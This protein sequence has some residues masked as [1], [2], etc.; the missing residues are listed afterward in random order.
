MPPRVA[1]ARSAAA[2]AAA[3]LV[4]G[5]GGC[6]E[7]DRPEPDPGGGTGGG[8]AGASVPFELV[9]TDDVAVSPD[10]RRVLADCWEG[11]CTWDVA[12]GALTLVPDRNQVAVAPDWSTVATVDGGDVVLEG[13]PDGAP[14][15]TFRGLDDAE[16]TDGSPVTAVAFS[17]DGQLLAAAGLD[18]RVVVWSVD[19]GAEQAAFTAA[20]APQT[21]VFSPDGSRLA[22][23]GG[24]PVEVRDTA[25][26]Q[27]VATVQGSGEAGALAWS[28]DGRALL[29]PGAGDVP[30][31]WEAPAFEPVEELPGVRLHEL[32]VSP[33]GRTV[34]VTAFDTT[35]VRLWRPRA[36]AGAGGVRSLVGHVA[37]PGAVAFA[38]DGTRLYSVAADDGVRAWDV[39]SGRPVARTFEVPEGPDR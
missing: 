25:D 32:A 14:V 30:T 35:A 5:L 4:T 9:L 34:A 39:A 11:I 29:G 20:Y 24:G 18:G 15:R 38:P 17:P 16:V 12:T 23:A 10:G 8:T 2:L 6:G 27:A 33:D 7:A 37:D 1:R 3:V 26:G 22:L 36:L 13:L 28:P 19:D 21:L 31:V